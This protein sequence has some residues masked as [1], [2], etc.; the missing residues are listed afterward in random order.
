MF[1]ICTKN[2]TTYLFMTINGQ[3]TLF[4]QFF[5]RNYSKK[6]LF[7]VIKNIKNNILLF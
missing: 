2:Y 3:H 7:F 1:I 5:M 6:F 4:K